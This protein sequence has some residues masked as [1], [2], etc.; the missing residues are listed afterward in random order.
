MIKSRR[1]RKQVAIGKT[2]SRNTIKFCSISQLFFELFGHYGTKKQSV[3]IDTAYH[4]ERNNQL[5]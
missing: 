5:K 4:Y 1:K 2:S 3:Q